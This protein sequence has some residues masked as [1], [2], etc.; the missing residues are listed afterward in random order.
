M[1]TSTTA[2]TTATL[3]LPGVTVA[4]AGDVHFTGRTEPLLADPSTAF[5]PIADA[6][7]AA[8]ITMVNLETAIT[9]RGVEEPKEFHFPG[10]LHCVGRADRSRR[11][12]CLNGQQPR[13]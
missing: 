2:S 3:P 6:L 1:P 12:R 5:G 10:A 4:F 8:D 7:S 9:E 11:R 13:S